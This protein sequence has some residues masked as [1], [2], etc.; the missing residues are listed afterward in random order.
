M[1]AFSSRGILPYSV[2]TV[3]EESLAWGTLEDPQPK[4]LKKV[5]QSLDVNLNRLPSRAEIFALNEKNRRLLWGAMN[6]VFIS[7]PDLYREFGLLPDIPRYNERGQEVKRAETGHT[8][9]E[10]FNVRPARRVDSDGG[11]HTELIATIHQRRPVALDGK[12]MTNGWFWFRGG[13]TLIIDPRLEKSEIRYVLTKNI[14]SQERLERQRRTVSGSSL[15]P[16]RALYFGDA[17]GEPFAMMHA[18]N[19]GDVDA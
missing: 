14:A 10:V 8:T 18:E 16:L 4:W 1:E 13:A 11:L 6:D 9:F 15:S 5:I 7:Q 3:S 12:D 19:A 2:R 17:S